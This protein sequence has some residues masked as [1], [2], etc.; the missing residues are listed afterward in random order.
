MS[1]FIVDSGIDT[2]H[3]EFAA[4]AA[5]GQTGGRVE[6]EV[7]NLFDAYN[8]KLLFDNDEV[9]HGTHVAATIGG[10]NVGVAPD[11]N[12]YGIRVLDGSGRRAR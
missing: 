2:N 4:A 6:R 5:T 10:R 11:A 8:D 7:R 3:V 1:C 12:L 9:G